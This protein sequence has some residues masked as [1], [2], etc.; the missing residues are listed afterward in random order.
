VSAALSRLAGSGA[1]HRVSDGWLLVGDPPAPP[2]V[3][4]SPSV[5][6]GAS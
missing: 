1:V 5:E 2:H 3:G 6:L 4:A